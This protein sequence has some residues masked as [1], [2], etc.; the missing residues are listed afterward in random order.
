MSRKELDEEI[1]SVLEL[2]YKQLELHETAKLARTTKA[3]QKEGIKKLETK[4]AKLLAKI[5]RFAN[6][7]KGKRKN[8]NKG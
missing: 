2:L 7:R 5:K 8:V 6:S 4:T 1:D 3:L